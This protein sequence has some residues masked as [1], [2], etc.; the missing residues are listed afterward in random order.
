MTLARLRR[1]RAARGAAADRCRR[2]A[3][4]RSGRRRSASTCGSSST[5]RIGASTSAI[6]PRWQRLALTYFA[7]DLNYVLFVRRFPEPQPAPEQL[8]YFLGGVTWNWGSWQ[9]ASLLGVVARRS[10][11][12]GVGVGLR[13]RARVARRDVLAAVRAQELDRRRRCRVRGGRGVRS[14]AEAQ[15]RR[16]D[17]GRRRRRP[18]AR[19][20][21][22]PIPPW[23]APDGRLVRACSASSVWPS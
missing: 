3:L 14:A 5:A 13:R 11:P 2:A 7:A 4:G 8:P 9:A 19:P 15:H 22:C 17:R 18:A 23:S 21:R 16:R 1:Q 12:D 6:L 10:R 20:R